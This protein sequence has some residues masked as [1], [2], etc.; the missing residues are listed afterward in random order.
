MANTGQRRAAKSTQ[1]RRSAFSPYPTEAD[2]RT[3][4][5]LARRPGRPP[6]NPRQPSAFFLETERTE[7]GLIAPVAA[8]FLTNREC[9]WRCLMCDLWKHTLTDRVPAG[10]IAAQMDYALRRLR[11][12]HEWLLL[13][14]REK[15]RSILK[16]Y[17]AGSFFDPRAIPPG[18]HPA[19]AAR[20]ASFQRVIVECH[21]ALVGEAAVRFRDLL[22]ETS[23]QQ[24]ESAGPPQLEVALGLETVHPRVLPRLNKRMTLPMFARAAALLRR[25]G[26]ALRVFVL[27]Q[28]PFLD[29]AQAIEWARRST[30]F[31]FDCGASVV[32][33]IPTR[34][35]NG[36]LD[37]LAA[38]GAFT[39]PRVSNLETALVD[40]LK[41]G[42]N[43]G[44]VFA[45][46]WDLER[47]ARCPACF[48]ARQAR[49]RKMNLTQQVQPAVLC[50]QCGGD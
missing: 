12:S 19:I 9:P 32:C 3:R 39:S 44:R 24:P 22:V 1:V 47:F 23:R 27:I 34:G 49:L 45:D 14:A 46:L 15:E 6:L 25:H 8:V 42:R 17:N 41:L 50:S 21:P 48:Q 16:L 33:L 40:G 43:R 4:W 2:K 20:A 35:G 18:E 26:I 13:E 11:Q 5:I 38:Q 29:E 36:A 31:A 28:P 30:D 37:A 10:A 7:A